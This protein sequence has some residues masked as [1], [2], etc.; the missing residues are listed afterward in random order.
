MTKI[1][2][3]MLGFTGA[4]KHTVMM[5]S[6]LVLALLACGARGEFIVG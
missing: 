3:A 4:A 2:Y 5:K 1:R 6:L